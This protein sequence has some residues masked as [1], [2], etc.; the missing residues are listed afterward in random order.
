[1]G[2]FFHQ[3]NIKILYF[4][5]FIWLVFHKSLVF[6]IC[7]FLKTSR[8][9]YKN[10]WHAYTNLHGQNTFNLSKQTFCNITLEFH[11]PRI[12]SNA[13]HFLHILIALFVTKSTRRVWRYQRVNQ[14]PYTE[15]QQTMAKRERTN[16]DGHSTK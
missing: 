2:F 16:K 6:V 12:V 13:N 9:K 5:Y 14:N 1:M 15:D 3:R 8:Y 7:L 10:I 11:I 4:F